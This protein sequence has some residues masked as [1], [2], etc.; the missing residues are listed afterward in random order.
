MLGENPRLGEPDASFFPFHKE[1]T[2]GPSPSRSGFGH[3]GGERRP[4]RLGTPL[5]G[6]LPARASRGER[7]GAFGLQL[8]IS[9][10]SIAFWN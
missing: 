5:S 8:I 7:E 1:A 2:V 10:I 9:L 6:S 4:F 3:A